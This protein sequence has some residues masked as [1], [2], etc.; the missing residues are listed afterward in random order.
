MTE[1]QRAW[2]SENPEFGPVEYRIVSL[3]QWSD[4]GY[5]FEN[6]RFSRDDGKTLFLDTGR[7]LRVGRKYYVT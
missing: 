3:Y 7:A 2:L 5:L 6:G 1:A 4:Q